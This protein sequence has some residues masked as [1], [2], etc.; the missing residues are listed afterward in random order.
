MKSYSRNLVLA[1]F[2]GLFA[3]G[4]IAA[5]AAIKLGDSKQKVLRTEGK[6]A[7]ITRKKNHNGVF[8]NLYYAQKDITYIVDMKKNT[9]CEIRSGQ[10]PGTCYPCTGKKGEDLCM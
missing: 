1:V 8:L 6:P 7:S 3:Y 2:T 4:A 10:E 5:D 9:V